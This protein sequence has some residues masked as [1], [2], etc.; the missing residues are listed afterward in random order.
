M[1]IFRILSCPPHSKESVETGH[2]RSWSNQVLCCLIIHLDT[3]KIAM[4]K[5]A[6]SYYSFQNGIILVR[7]ES[8][9]ESTFSDG[10]RSRL[11]SVD[12]AALAKSSAVTCR[13][14]LSWPGHY[15]NPT[16]ITITCHAV[17]GVPT[18]QKICLSNILCTALS[19]GSTYAPI[20]GQ[21]VEQ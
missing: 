13:C 5:I 15:P 12:S 11:K 16:G 19:Y 20:S 8:E 18:R 17:A 4:I 1:V 14:W 2:I 21:N 7:P 3:M 9:L 6:T 10:S